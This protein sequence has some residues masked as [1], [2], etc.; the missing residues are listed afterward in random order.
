MNKDVPILIFNEFNKP[1]IVKRGT[2]I[3]SAP[4]PMNPAD[5]P[6]ITPMKVNPKI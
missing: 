2:I 3:T 5:N 1:N 6:L 4:A